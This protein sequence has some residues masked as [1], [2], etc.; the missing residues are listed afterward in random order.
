MNKVLL[1]TKINNFWEKDIWKSNVKHI[2]NE[3]I[4]NIIL[5]IQK[6]NNSLKP[7]KIFY[8]LNDG[9]FK[10]K[11]NTKIE[12]Q[13]D[14]LKKDNINYIKTHADCIPEYHNLIIEHKKGSLFLQPII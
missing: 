11:S 14:K 3:K 4:K 10:I 7:N 6:L 13:I 8:L 12:N 5:Q 9:D 1:E 2:H